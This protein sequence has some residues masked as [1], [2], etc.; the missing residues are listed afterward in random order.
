MIGSD[1]TMRAPLIGLLVCLAWPASAWASGSLVISLQ[2]DHSRAV[3]GTVTASPEGGGQGQTCATRGGRC[4]INGLAAGRVRVSATLV[5]GGLVPASTVMVQ[6]GRPVSVRLT[7]LPPP[8]APGMQQTGGGGGNA[9]APQVLPGGAQGGTH[10]GAPGAGGVR[11]QGGA[12][13]LVRAM[14]APGGQVVPGRGP[15][16][17]VVTPGHGGAA[18]VGTN[19]AMQGAAVQAGAAPR[20]LGTGQHASVMGTTQDQRGRRVE[21]T[22]TVTQSGHTI[23]TVSTTGGSFTCFDLAA[24]TYSVSFTAVGGQ[25]T[26]QNLSVAG[27]PASSIRLTIVR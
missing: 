22:V 5:R 18:P 10:P 7:A 2:D 9:P 26:S 27:G 11:V 1:N 23:G 8:T 4:T 15:A 3:E 14:P 24:G 25:H 12:G 16:P 17:I 20:N 6:N 13:A 21:G 19:V